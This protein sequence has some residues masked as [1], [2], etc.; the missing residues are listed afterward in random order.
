M[1]ICIYNQRGTMVRMVNSPFPAWRVEELDYGIR[2]R[3]GK[4]V[5]QYHAA[6]STEDVVDIIG[7]SPLFVVQLKEGL[8]SDG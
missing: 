1:T 3:L 8:Q 7:D 5:G 4:L 6:F 2:I